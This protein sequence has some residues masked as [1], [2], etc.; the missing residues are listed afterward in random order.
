MN[1]APTELTQEEKRIKIAEAC[2]WVK[3]LNIYQEEVYRLGD[4]SR[5]KDRLP[6]YF[7]DL[8]ACREMKMALED[9]D[10][11]TGSRWRYIDELIS[12]TGSG[13]MEIHRNVFT[14]ENASASDQAEAF[15]RAMN[16]W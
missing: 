3:G 5:Y 16:L 7:N 13:F 4:S 8:D 1:E 12:I 9:S 11:E 15:G 2:G 14:V 10:A 6:D